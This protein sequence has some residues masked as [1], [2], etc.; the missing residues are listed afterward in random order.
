MSTILYDTW[1]NQE[2]NKLLLNTDEV[3]LKPMS[4]LGLV[5]ITYSLSV[6]VLSPSSV[7]LLCLG[8]W[9]ILNHLLFN[10]FSKYHIQ[11]IPTVVGIITEL[12]NL[13]WFICSAVIFKEYKTLISMFST[14][15][16]CK[17]QSHALLNPLLVCITYFK[18]LAIWIGYEIYMNNMT[19]KFD[20]FIACTAIFM[21]Y[22]TASC[23]NFTSHNNY[24]IY[25]HYRDLRETKFLNDIIVNSIP[26][27]I[28][29]LD[30]NLT[31][32]MKNKSFEELITAEDIQQITETFKKFKYNRA[33]SIYETLDRNI[34]KDI[35]LFLDT[36]DIGKSIRLGIVDYEDKSLELKCT[37]IM[38]ETEPGIL[39][40]VRDVTV[41]LDIQKTSVELECRG[42]I[43]RSLSHELRTP[44]NCII[45]MMD[46]IS[47]EQ[48]SDLGHSYLRMA[49]SNSFYLLNV[50]ND[51]I[52]FSQILSHS[53]ILSKQ[54]FNLKETI[55][56]TFNMMKPQIESKGLSGNLLIDSLLPDQ[57]YN[58]ENRVRQIIV[59]LLSNSIKFTEK[60][61][62]SLSA[63]MTSDC[64]CKI[65]V[66][67]SG[68]GIPAS[69][70]PGLFSFKQNLGKSGTVTSGLGL[71][72]SY[73][74]AN[75]LGSELRVHSKEGVGSK[76]ELN[77]NLYHSGLQNHI[78]YE[79]SDED[80]SMIDEEC[81][82]KLL[83]TSFINQGCLSELDKFPPVLIVDDTPINRD[84]LKLLLSREN[85]KTD[86]ANCGC[87]AIEKIKQANARRQMYDIVIMD[88][89]MPTM[90]GLEAASAINH[91]YEEN[92]IS[93]LPTIIAHSAFSSQADINDALESGMQGYIPKPVTRD[94]FLKIITPY[95]GTKQK[96][97][98]I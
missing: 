19:W 53:F 42:A 87:T 30:R 11:H 2:I 17:F 1:K 3:L 97:R 84:I 22:V 73:K 67:D 85:I 56:T 18:H 43:V 72:I 94:N 29:L 48:L 68:I 45:N 51:I 31:V 74:L 28:M 79:P 23:Q 90:N 47:Y 38:M 41:L 96:R 6:D 34:Y 4:L 64:K 44:V 66:E 77:L 89:D 60:G 75:I 14:I 27:G 98:L 82:P 8:I 33:D 93:S 26:E 9:L 21:I 40:T 70:M 20:P 92:T 58:D 91:M 49:N 16:F 52:D 39:L 83:P 63:L 71:H 86:E 13:A 78:V 61:F 35:V 46:E 95:L 81:K 69:K 65:S 12:T 15:Y 80:I 24:E 10:Y 88:C 37:K 54:Y 59:N 36:S 55:L 62:I 57:I 50:I 7:Y 5:F 32:K 76:F 25:A